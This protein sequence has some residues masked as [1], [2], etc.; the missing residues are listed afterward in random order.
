MILLIGKVAL[1][2]SNSAM[3]FLELPGACSFFI[4]GQSK[5]SFSLPRSAN[6]PN[7]AFLAKTTMFGRLFSQPGVVRCPAA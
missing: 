2:D 1:R 6:D 4:G 5:I 3:C 7:F